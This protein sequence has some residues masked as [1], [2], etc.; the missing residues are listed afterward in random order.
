MMIVR[1]VTPVLEPFTNE[2]QQWIISPNSNTQ[3]RGNR[4]TTAPAPV[5]YFSSSSL[6]PAVMLLPE[7][8]FVV[9]C[10]C[11]FFLLGLSR[12]SWGKGHPTA[13]FVR[14]VE[15]RGR[16]GKTLPSSTG[17]HLPPL[18]FQSR[19][20]SSSLLCCVIL[21]G[22][23]HFLLM[24]LIE[25]GGR[26]RIYG[27]GPERSTGIPAFHIDSYFFMPTSVSEPH[28]LPQWIFAISPPF[29]SSWQVTEKLQEVENETIMKVADLE[30]Q[31][32]QK[33]KDLSSIKVRS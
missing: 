28:A 14:A 26:A 12:V 23:S 7:T 13:P 15:L 30:K 8:T 9:L 3:A 18:G 25:G 33:D 19:K 32:L 1:L 6:S 22:I 17:W 21:P 31:L 16:W 27:C 2:S 10:L 11:S 24:R 5:A 20:Q 29:S 4:S